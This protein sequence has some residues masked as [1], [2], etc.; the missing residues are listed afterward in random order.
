L[1]TLPGARQ[2]VS[3]RQLSASPPGA[4]R[5]FCTITCMFPCK[6]RH[7][8][9]PPPPPQVF[10]PHCRLRPRSVPRSPATPLFRRPP[11]RGRCSGKTCVG[12]PSSSVPR[13]SAPSRSPP[14]TYRTAA[15]WKQ[16]WRRWQLCVG[17]SSLEANADK[18]KVPA[19]ARAGARAGR[20]P[21]ARASRLYH[22]PVSGP[23]S[24]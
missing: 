12:A 22:R 20:E 11:L 16:R 6:S 23:A 15:R 4:T 10:P 3:P 1:G 8:K 7:P 21:R 9:V 2:T 13:L 5:W 19:I 14:S 17:R 24:R 18:K